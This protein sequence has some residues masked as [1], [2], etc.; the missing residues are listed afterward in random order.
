MFL[1]T[2]KK[3]VNIFLYIIANLAGNINNIE[4]YHINRDCVEGPATTA[5]GGRGE[6]VRRLTA[7]SHVA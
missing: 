7:R 1:Q 3:K 4:T 6:G 2:Y 5:V